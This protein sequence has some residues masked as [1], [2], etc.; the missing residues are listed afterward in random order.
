MKVFIDAGHNFNKW[1]TGAEGSGL[2]E[3]DITFAIAKKL[4]DLLASKGIEIKLSRPTLETNLGTDNASSINARY[5]MANNW[6]ADYFI[7]IHTNAGGGTGAE[8]LYF[9]KDSKDYAKVIQENYIK[10]IVLADRGV[11][12]RDDV[13]VLINT[14]MPAVLIETGFIDNK[15][16]AELLKNH[17]SEIAQAIANGFYEFLG[18]KEDVEMRYNTLAEV[19]DWAKATISKLIDKKL[20]TGDGNKLDLSLD[21]IRIFVINDRAGLYG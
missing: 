5:T 12:Y 14:K 15:T 21:M 8:T 13:G 10:A 19:P 2:K 16:D 18:I 9:K 20:L 17:Q 7:S 3:Q 6:G 4:G 11:K 1:N